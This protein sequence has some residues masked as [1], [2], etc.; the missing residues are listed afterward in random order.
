M[1]L[2]FGTDCV[3][4]LVDTSGTL[5]AVV[6]VQNLVDLVYYLF[7]SFDSFLDVL[8]FEA[9]VASVSSQNG[10]GTQM[11]LE[12]FQFLVG[13]CELHVSNVQPCVPERF[14][15]ASQPTGSANHNLLNY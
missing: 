2:V 6:Q 9:C 12:A 8:D 4:F 13:L 1:F 15:W 5:W 14:K 7:F 11:D 3:E 10:Y